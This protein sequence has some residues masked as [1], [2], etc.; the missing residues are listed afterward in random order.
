MLLKKNILGNFWYPGPQWLPNDFG[1]YFAR[2][3]EICGPD[4]SPCYFETHADSVFVV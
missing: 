2:I 3:V 1:A 4:L